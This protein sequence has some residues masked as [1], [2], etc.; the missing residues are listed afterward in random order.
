MPLRMGFPFNPTI[1]LNGLPHRTAADAVSAELLCG[2]V[3][4]RRARGNQFVC[5][6]RQLARIALQFLYTKPK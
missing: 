3:A 4:G 6:R 2:A 5:V 1:L